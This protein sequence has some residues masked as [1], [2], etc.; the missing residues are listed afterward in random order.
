MVADALAI[1][2]TRELA[3]QIRDECEQLITF[4]KPK[5]TSGC[6]YGGALGQ[7]ERRREDVGREPRDSSG[8]EEAPCS[9]R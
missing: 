6:V 4:H 7:W 9:G 5:M 1:S 3:S 8:G 2:P